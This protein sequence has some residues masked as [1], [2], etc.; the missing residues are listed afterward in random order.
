MGIGGLL[1][2]LKEIQKPAHVRDWKGKTVAVDAYVWLH[3]G[4]YGCAE[5][6]ALGKPTTKY[7][8][9]AMHR[10]RML[11]YYG[12]TPMLVFDGGLLPSKMGTE[13]ERERRRADALA[14]GRA[15][16]AE[17]KGSQARECFVKAVDVTPAMAYQL[18]KAL[19][20]EGVQ[21]VVAP[22]E[23]DPQLCYLEKA[24]IVDA[25]V[26]ED[27]DLLV[28]GCKNVLFKLDGEGNCV[29]ISRDDF[30][31]CREYNLAGWTDAEFRQMAI[32]SGCDYVDSIVGL[33]LKTAYRLMRK[34]KTA[35]KVIQ[36]VRLEGQL[37]V[38][39]NY[40]DEFR[41]AELTFLHQH[42]F[43]PVERK[44]VHLHPLPAGKT[45][46]DLPF[47]GPL[48]EHEFACGLADGEI[49]PISKEAIVDLVPDALSPQK[50]YRS[51][52]FRPVASTSKGNSKGKMPAAPVKGAGS[53]LSFFKPSAGASSSATAAPINPVKAVANQRRVHLVSSSKDKGK[54]KENEEK[55]AMAGRSSKFFGG[56]GAFKGKGKER[57]VEPEPEP[58]FEEDEGMQDDG[59]DAEA[60]AALR[61]VEMQVDTVVVAAS[62]CGGVIEEDS[63]SDEGVITDV[64][65]RTQPLPQPVNADHPSPPTPSR[66]IH[67]EPSL[68]SFVSSPTATPPPRKRAKHSHP[69]S[70]HPLDE[71]A[72]EPFVPSDAGISSP[73]E[74]TRA[75]AG[76]GVKAEEEDDDADRLSSPMAGPSRLGVKRAAPPLG[77]VKVEPVEVKSVVG[78]AAVK[79]RKAAAPAIELSSDPIVLSSDAPEP[80]TPEAESEE[81]T[82]RPAPAKGGAKG[83]GKK[84]KQPAQSPEGKKKAGLQRERRGVGAVRARV[85][86]G[87]EEEKPLKRSGGGSGSGKKRAKKEVHEE[88]QEEVDE[89]VKSVAAS[90]RAK[91]MM[92]A[93]SK[94][95]QGKTPFRRS[96]LPTPNTTSRPPSLEKPSSS[97]SP[98]KTLGRSTTPASTTSA[99]RAPLSPKSSNRIDR[100]VPPSFS[101]SLATKR[102]S[103][104]P[105]SSSQEDREPSL[106]PAK[107]QR[108][109]SLLADVSAAAVASK[110]AVDLAPEGSSSS[111]P[112]VVTNPRLLAFK[113]TGTVRRD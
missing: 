6:L 53:L 13:D 57:E 32:L 42:V 22:Y 75:D 103:S 97:S 67:R 95:P 113:F 80:W 29:S 58:P 38:P 101:Q 46:E 72:A 112:V 84:A 83:K 28:F 59:D 54:G 35:E 78:A 102:A 89:A 27:S 62:V 91:F 17:G 34:Y 108:R 56:G 71:D 40:P 30:S 68:P 23:A 98:K 15:F 5:D 111:S 3:R 48:L 77:K 4:A 66:S 105:S 96:L 21:Y 50:P 12:V 74:S 36:F 82:P 47:I 49:D 18:I 45:A 65:N 93:A 7:V 9:Y 11:K 44:L 41:R 16:A 110:P 70:P 85:D 69:P 31:Q 55:P 24:G 26:T 8:N 104:G 1:P 61:E 37:S 14:R 81:R 88:E 33:G 64:T 107:K 87:E 99:R 86:D 60:E 51:E 10:V 39:R 25:I 73:A 90:W 106:S 19:R 52:P 43:D 100:R 63:T 76:W 109:S 20:R 2:L 92:P 79:G 94:T